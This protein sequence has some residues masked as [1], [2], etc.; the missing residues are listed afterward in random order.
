MM[1]ASLEVE[2]GLKFLAIC[3]KKNQAHGVLPSPSSY[4]WLISS[5]EQYSPGIIRMLV[6]VSRCMA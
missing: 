3:Y 5:F 6:T 2:A 4:L 1:H